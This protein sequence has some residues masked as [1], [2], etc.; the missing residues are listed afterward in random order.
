MLSC[1]H[2]HYA[3]RNQIDLI[4]K[5]I[6]LSLIQL[7]YLFQ[8]LYSYTFSLFLCA[9]NF[10]SHSS[11]DIYWWNIFCISSNHHWKFYWIFF[12]LNE[13]V[14]L[15]KTG[16]NLYVYIPITNI[17][18]CEIFIQ[19]EHNNSLMLYSLGTTRKWRFWEL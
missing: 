13:T 9:V 15:T 5:S 7:T 8:I 18:Y 2:I 1:L 11:P 19:E 6:S 17:E 16:F 4:L 14:S 12:F 3:M 10:V